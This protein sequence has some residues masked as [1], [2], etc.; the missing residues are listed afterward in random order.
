[1]TT[2]TRFRMNRLPRPSENP[3]EEPL[4]GVVQGL[5]ASDIEERFARAHYQLKVDFRFQ[6]YVHTAVG[7][8]GE[9]KQVDFLT[10]FS[11]TQIAFEIDGEIGHKTIE[12][13]EYD[14]FRDALV[15]EQLARMG[16]LPIVRVPWFDLETQEQTNQTFKEL[17][18]A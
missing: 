16:I 2:R 7:I 17:I 8:P 6:W 18:N 14:D 12:Q 10:D 9:D 13:Q 11:G 5:E 3:D 15:N 4:T 1:M